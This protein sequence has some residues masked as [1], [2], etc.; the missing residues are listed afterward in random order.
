MREELPQTARRRHGSLSSKTKNPMADLVVVGSAS[1][2]A[3]LV[4]SVLVGLPKEYEMD[5]EV[6]QMSDQLNFH[7]QTI[8]ADSC[9]SLVVSL[10]GLQPLI[11]YLRGFVEPCR[12][13]LIFEGCSISLEIMHAQISQI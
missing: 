1:Q 4:L 10:S 7:L 11:A 6:L 2:E 5:V 12:Q 13:Q 3:D 9:P 8:A